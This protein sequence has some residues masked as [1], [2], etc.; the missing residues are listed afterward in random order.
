MKTIL[1]NSNNI[2]PIPKKFSEVYYDVSG[3]IPI[4]FDFYTN[5]RLEV[6]DVESH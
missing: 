3:L 2:R 1:H 5:Y 4:K 6:R